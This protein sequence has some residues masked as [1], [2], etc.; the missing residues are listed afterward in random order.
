MMTN[1]IDA[2]KWRY[3]TK[4]FDSSK[5]VS[6]EDIEHLK[7][8]MQLSASSYGLQ[9]YKI[10]IVEDEQIRQQLLPAAFNQSQIVDASHLIVIANKVNFEG[11]IID[12][13]VDNISTTRDLDRTE[14][15]GMADYMKTNILKLSAEQ[16]ANWTAKQTYIVLGNLLSAAAHLKIDTCP[17]EGFNAEAFNEILGLDKQNYNASVII[18]IGYRSVE[19]K[20]QGLAKVRRAKDD[21][22]Q[23]I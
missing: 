13:Y 4:K 1:Y 18:S 15:N 6:A 5:K 19:D 16:K 17:M 14:L 8:V 21:L 2:L 9:P 11:E 7:E 3:A 20:T 22:F 10:F 12:T 23:T